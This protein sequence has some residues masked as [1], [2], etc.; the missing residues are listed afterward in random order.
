MCLRCGKSHG[1]EGFSVEFY[2]FF[3]ELL[4]QEFLDS[5]NAS[6][7]ENEL[8]ISQHRGVITLILKEDANCWRPIMLLSVDYK[9]ASKAIATRIEKVL[10]LIINSNQTGFIKGRYIGENIRLINDIL[11]QTKAQDIPG[12]LL[13]LDFRK[14]FD[15]VEWGFIQNTLD[16]HNFGCTCNIKQWV[17]TFY[18]NTESSVLHNGFTTN[19]FKLSRGVRQGCPLSPY[20]FILGAKIL[21]ARVRLERNIEGITIYN[22]EHKTS[23][24]ADDTS[25]F[26]KNVD[27]ITNTIEILRL[28][29]NI[30][31]L[32]LNLGKTKAIWLG[33]WRHKVSKPLGLNWMNEPVRALGIFTSYNE[34]ENDKKNVA[35]KID[36]LNIKLDL[37]RGRKLSL[38]GKCLIVKTLGIS[39]IVYS[40]SMLDIS[41]NDT[42]RITCKKFIFSFIWNKKPDKIKRNILCQDYTKGELW[43]PDL[44]ILFQS[45]RLTGIS[46]LLIPGETTI[47]SWKS[48]P[49]HFLKKYG[50]LNF[51]LQ[52]N[53][54]F[55]FL[56]KSGIPNFYRKILANFLEIRNLYQHDNGQARFDS[57]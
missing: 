9:I 6:Y 29:G 32:K 48:I 36:N 12:I 41:H 23:Q 37:W 11:E 24:F 34:Q 5:I 14:A 38:F 19:Y 40:A 53:Y 7:N 33:S 35:R 26:L 2:Q 25:L 52:C 43:A 10:R 8:S 1:E 4:G 39:Q 13:L 31:G 15:T 50:G 45:L 16:L 46:R 18:N 3:F 21:A 51:L 17:E 54:N 27:S 47:E 28:F 44:D 56:E 42:S 30:S 20:L 57:L 55:K 49:S 22:T